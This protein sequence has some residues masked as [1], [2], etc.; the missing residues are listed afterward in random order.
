MIQIL[1]K[2]VFRKDKFDVNNF[3][4]ISLDY[5]AGNPLVPVIEATSSPKFEYDKMTIE[6]YFYDKL[7]QKII[8]EKNKYSRDLK[9]LVLYGYV[10]QSR[11]GKNGL[12]AISTRDRNLSGIIEKFNAQRYRDFCRK[13][14]VL[15]NNFL[16]PVKVVTHRKSGERIVGVFS[17]E[18]RESV[19]YEIR[20]YNK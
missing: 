16:I 17:R 12:V 3:I 10:G 6:I 13:L 11:G 19:L 14:G 4:S 7:L 8:R 15:Q 1:E 18:P 2:Q 5:L 20:N 9:D